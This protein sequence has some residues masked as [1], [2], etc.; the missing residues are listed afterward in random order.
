MKS[1]LCNFL[2]ESSRGQ[3]KFYEPNSVKIILAAGGTGGHLYPAIA[4]VR[5]L[6]KNPR[7]RLLFVGT[8]EGIEERVLRTENLIPAGKDSADNFE[9]RSISVK[10]F[11]RRNIAEYPSF[12]LSALAACVQSFFLIMKFKPDVA[13]G[14]GGYVSGPVILVSALCGV[15]TLIHEQNTIAGLTNRILALFVQK[16]CI[17]FETSRKFFPAHKIEFTGNPVR[18]E[19]L[20]VCRVSSAKKLGLD[21]D[22]KTILVFGGS[23]GARKLNLVMVS[24]LKLLNGTNLQ[25]VHISGREDYETI[26]SLTHNQQ[27]E[28]LNYFLYPYLDNMWDALAAAD[29]VVSRAGATSIAEIT[30]RGLPSI[31]IPYPYASDKHQEMNASVLKE[32]GAARIIPDRELTAEKMAD[33]ILSLINDTPALELMAS[34][35]R[36]ISKPEATEKIVSIIY[37]LAR[38]R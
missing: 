4:I 33:E 24:A 10:K 38:K 7:A 20:S 29:L 32:K 23:R 22:K 34:A 3:G 37:Q 27:L 26:R 17:T 14:V 12:I 28:T 5:E 21:P 8:K 13:V 31:L 2:S 25:I 18:K 30:A 35:S 19:V 11:V 9:F 16:I 15:P 6:L 36:F 1:C